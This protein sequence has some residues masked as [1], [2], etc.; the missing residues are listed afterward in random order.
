MGKSATKYQTTRPF[1][2]REGEQ[3]SPR[4]KF[5]DELFGRGTLWE[6]YMLGDLSNK[7]RKLWRVEGQHQLQGVMRQ[8]SVYLKLNQI[9]LGFNY[10]LSTF[11]ICL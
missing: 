10:C 9:D 11:V 5:P 4:S 7:I 1:Y 6:I 8:A 3:T 2:K